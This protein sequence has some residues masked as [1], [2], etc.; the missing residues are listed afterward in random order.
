VP[1]RSAMS[2]RPN[3]RSTAGA[4]AHGQPGLLVKHGGR[5]A[6]RW[7]GAGRAARPARRLDT[8][9]HVAAPR[10]GAAPWHRPSPPACKARGPGRAVSGRSGCVHANAASL[11]ARSS[12][13]P[14]E[15]TAMQQHDVEHP[16]PQRVERSGE[17]ST[18]SARARRSE[19]RGAVP[20]EPWAARCQHQQALRGCPTP[21]LPPH[22][23]RSRAAESRSM[24]A[25]AASAHKRP[26]AAN[27]FADD[28]AATRQRG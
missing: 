9:H 26:A 8:T 24:T 19:M 10:R 27:Q 5:S 16:F 28:A 6:T 11:P 13:T 1:A 4:V 20:A 21:R 18:S 7:F 23:L 14:A 3:S 22:C 25:R 17:G 15:N 2:E 12:Q